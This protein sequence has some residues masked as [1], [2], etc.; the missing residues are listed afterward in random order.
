MKMF[1]CP[2]CGPISRI[3]NRIP[4][5]SYRVYL[6]I[7]AAGDIKEDSYFDHECEDEFAEYYE[8]PI[9]GRRIG[10]NKLEITEVV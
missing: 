1:N 9:C 7:N 6:S 10:W 8:C 3:I 2:K 5:G 4:Y